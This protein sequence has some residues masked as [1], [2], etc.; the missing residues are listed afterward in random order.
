MQ[1]NSL[2]ANLSADP[3]TARPYRLGGNGLRNFFVKT[4]LEP[5]TLQ[6][7]C[8]DQYFFS[9]CSALSLCLLNTLPSAFILIPTC[10]PFFFA[11]TA[12]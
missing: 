12:S 4:V 2:T 10:L 9:W 6:N 3:L 5:E 8:F 1:I 7:R 11:T